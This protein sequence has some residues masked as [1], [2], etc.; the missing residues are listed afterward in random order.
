MEQGNISSKIR[1]WSG[2]ILCS[3]CLHLSVLLLFL[4]T[5]QSPPIPMMVPVAPPAAMM[6]QLSTV[7]SAPPTP[8]VQVQAGP[9]QIESESQPEP[10]PEKDASA[11]PLP[12]PAISKPKLTPP[13]KIQEKAAVQIAQAK[14]T[15]PSHA[16][17]TTKAA[18]ITS[19]A[20]SL[21]APPA[22]VAT[23]SEEGRSSN[24]PNDTAKTWES[25]LLAKLERLKRYPSY[26]QRMKQEDIVYLH[27]AIDRS[28]HVLNYN[29]EASR[30][31]S[32]LDD[33][34]RALIRRAEPLPP[35]PVDVAGE[36]IEMV[37]PI[38]FFVRRA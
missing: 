36:R 9:T 16:R 17:Q 6:I 13:P 26:A 34:A 5:W 11:K 3:L 25:E 18:A 15:A 10:L 37:V 12:K 7:A 30:G 27:F 28:G 8:Q 4:I 23:A 2:L 29:I 38:E 33:E 20:P 22:S 19:A 31:F 35:P 32:L 1:R 14:K 24:A 21:P